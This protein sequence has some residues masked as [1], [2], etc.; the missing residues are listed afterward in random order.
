MIYCHAFFPFEVSEW[1]DIHPSRE[2]RFVHAQ[3]EKREME[4]YS[5]GRNVPVAN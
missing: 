4:T 2:G 5:F 3:T 1:L